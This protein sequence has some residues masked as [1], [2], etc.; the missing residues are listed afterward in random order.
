M[1]NSTYKEDAIILL[2]LKYEISNSGIT[3]LVNMV[4]LNIHKGIKNIHSAHKMKSRV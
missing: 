1:L 3:E 2:S 4:H